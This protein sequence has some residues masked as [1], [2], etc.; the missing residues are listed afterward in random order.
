MFYLTLV[1]QLILLLQAVLAI[2]FSI[3][4]TDILISLLK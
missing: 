3:K 4:V 1:T 2:Y